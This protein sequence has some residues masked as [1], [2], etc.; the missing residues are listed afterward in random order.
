MVVIA[1][2]VRLKHY[3]ATNLLRRLYNIRPHHVTLDSK[4]WTSCCIVRTVPVFPRHMPNKD[5]V[6]YMKL[7]QSTKK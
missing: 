1:F 5:S 7:H 6:R 2:K 3:I 4:P